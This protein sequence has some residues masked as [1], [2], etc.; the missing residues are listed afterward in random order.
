MEKPTLQRLEEILNEF[1]SGCHWGSVEIEFR[2]GHPVIIRK[3]V[4]ERK[5]EKTYYE[6][7]STMPRGR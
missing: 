3:I 2:Q 4:T 7:D 1:K 6:R 5:E